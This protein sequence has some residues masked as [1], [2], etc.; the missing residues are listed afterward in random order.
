MS[1]RT[2]NYD[3]ATDFTGQIAE[4]NTNRENI[5]RID[6][7]LHQIE[8]MASQGGFLVG[9]GVPSPSLGSE[10][11]MYFDSVNKNL[12]GPKTQSGWG[13]AISL[14]GP[15]GE[16]GIDGVDG[17]SAYEVA[18]DEGF[19]G[20][21]SQ[22]L[23]SLVGPQ[24]P[25]GQD[26]ANGSDGL[27]G[28]DGLSAYEI[29]VN[30]GFVG[31]ENQWLASL[32]GPQGIAGAQGATGPQGPQGIQGIQGVQG[33]QGPVGQP[34]TIADTYPS[35]AALLA[36]VPPA[37]T[38]DNQF[39]VVETGNVNDPDNGRLYLYT[40]LGGW[41]FI[42][43]LSGAEGMTGPQGLQGIQGIQ[44]PQGPA[45][46]DGADGQDGLSAYQVAVNEGFVGTE[47][48][49]LDSLQGPQGIAG[50]DGVDG[51]NGADGVNGLSAYEIAVA[52]GFV[53]TEAQWLVS[54]QGAQGLQGVQ[55]PQGPQGIQGIQGVQGPAGQDGADGVDGVDGIDGQDGLS[56]YEIAVNGGFVGTE[57]QWLASLEG[58]QGV[59]GPQGIQ[60]IQGVQGPA[61]APF[62][63]AD[64]YPSVAALLADVPP[65][66]TL[67]GQFA[68]VDTG[69]VNDVDNGKLYLYTD[70]NGWQFITDLSG[71]DGLTGPQGPQ[72][73]QGIQGPQGPAGPQGPQGLQGL[74]GATGATGAQGPQGL[75]GDTGPAGPQGP[76]GN[77]GATGPA[78]PQ[79]PQGNVGATGPAG[80]NANA[81]LNVKTEV[82]NYTLVLADA[83]ATGSSYL[84]MNSAAAQTITIP[85]NASV[86]FPIGAQLPGVQAGTGQV[87][88]QGAGGVT[89]LP[90][91]NSTLA[92][93]GQNASFCLVKVGTD[94]WR[95]AGDFTPL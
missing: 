61:G 72:G 67:N 50:V 21:I 41:Q 83:T 30:E 9:S 90:P 87:T 65:A 86:P 69:D 73:I 74:T 70:V 24:G 89:V 11:N 34:F 59:Q 44:G 1:F 92:L 14:E 4:D 28:Q 54:L 77:V 3:F 27:N 29:A 80:Q 71:V 40:T 62:V 6:E 58:P 20:T 13:A 52:Q 57:A 93:R 10:G 45:G 78:G 22:W 26:G 17:A 63:I 84:Q 81:L 88:I 47:A 56:A 31:T 25:A 8:Q 60:G 64:T 33:V 35:V 66:V 48:Q 15:A 49:W 68:V 18:V 42:T 23:A 95:A 39:A 46:Q 38:Q 12:Y 19:V 53:G 36:D 16:D 85:T 91:F 5:Y 32:Q 94:T 51:T 82:S 7:I 79:G 37:V 43:D 76:Q 2:P 75:T 55:G